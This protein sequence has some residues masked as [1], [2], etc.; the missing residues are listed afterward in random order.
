MC[1][2]HSECSP[3]MIFKNDANFEKL[4]SSKD[5]N[6][7]I[8]LKCRLARIAARK[9]SS[10]K[11]Q[12]NFSSYCAKF[13]IK[14]V[15][16]ICIRWNS[17]KQFSHI[18]SS[19]EFFAY[20]YVKRNISGLLSLFCCLQLFIFSVLAKNSHRWHAFATEEEDGGWERKYRKVLFRWKKTR[21]QIE[22]AL[23][24]SGCEFRASKHSSGLQ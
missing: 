21:K 15:Y 2:S 9:S 17:Q 11:F 5:S 13:R 19:L 14:L 12:T 22:S 20:K 8:K 23:F 18:K 3:M 24:D 6:N 4:V 7:S 1:F 16:R 10:R